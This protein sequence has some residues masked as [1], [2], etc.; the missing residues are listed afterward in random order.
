VGERWVTRPWLGFAVRVGILAIPF[1]ASLATVE[2]LRR[3]LP[4]TLPRWLAIGIMAVA[5]VLVGFG[6]ERIGRRLLPLSGLL[7]MT[8]LFPDRAPSRLRVLRRSASARQLR[9]R[10]ADPDSDAADAAATT[11]ALITA[12]GGHDQRTRGHSERV[13]VFAD[14]LAEQL[15]LSEPDHDRLRWAALLHDIGKL[16]IAAQVLNK[17]GKLDSD[18]WER[19]RDHP[20]D[21]AKLAAPL[22]EWLGEWGGGI[23]EHHERYDGTGYPLG[24]AGDEISRAGRIVAVIDAFETMTAARSY[25]QPMSARAAR[26][27]LARCAGTHFD[28]EVVRAF[29]QISLP[30]LLWAMGPMAMLVHLPYQRSLEATG[31]TLGSAVA[32]ASSATALAVSVAVIPA[33]PAPLPVRPPAV[34]RNVAAPAG[35]AGSRE[36]TFGRVG[37]TS[38]GSAGLLPGSTPPWVPE[39]M[40][41][42][43]GPAVPP[44]VSPRLPRPVRPGPI[45]TEL[46]LPTPG[47]PVP[48]LPG[49]EVPLPKLPLPPTP[50]QENWELGCPG[51]LA[52]ASSSAPSRMP[53]SPT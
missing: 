28:P 47:L 40:A 29:L 26:T 45:P 3:T 19:V 6:T 52:A 4:A 41:I 46:P 43:P 22:M 5:A 16:E 23:A 42:D 2:V 50:S 10:L 1:G 31:S 34:E 48:K 18:E 24:L 17:P 20:L 12:L 7:E 33:S 36:R 9:K 14:L 13:R 39:P 53:R 51:E 25:K 21:G 30:R 32:T 37:G 44:V 27:E 11:L 8:M 15:G 35:P 38:G 49:P